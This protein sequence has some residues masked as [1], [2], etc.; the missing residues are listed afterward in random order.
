MSAMITHGHHRHHRG[1]PS[2]G[3]PPEESI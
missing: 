3:H 2:R 1:T